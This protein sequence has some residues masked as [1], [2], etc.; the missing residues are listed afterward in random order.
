MNLI[1]SNSISI[2]FISLISTFLFILFIFTDFITLIATAFSKIP[3][4]L[5][6][7][8]FFKLLSLSNE[9]I[10][11]VRIYINK[12]KI[13]SSCEIEIYHKN[14]VGKAESFQIRFVYNLSNNSSIQN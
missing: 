13:F 2:E 10:I 6:I 14:L 4:F 8:N 1:F 7:R 3:L 11:A 12:N 9:S 5:E